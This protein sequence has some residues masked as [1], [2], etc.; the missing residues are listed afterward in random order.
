MNIKRTIVAVVTF[1]AGLYFILDFVVPRTLPV[2]ST[3]GVFVASDPAVVTVVDKNGQTIRREITPDV[4]ILTDQRDSSGEIKKTE[5]KARNTRA[6]AAITLRTAMVEVAQVV[7][8]PSGGA[9]SVVTTDGKTIR[10]G[11]GEGFYGLEDKSPEVTPVPGKR[12]VVDIRDARVQSMDMGA[13]T[14]LVK[15]KSKRLALTSGL[16]VLKQARNEQP[17]EV[18]A[19]EAKVGDTITVGPNTLFADNRDTAAQFNT[20]IETM[21][22]GMGLLSLALVNGRKLAKR[23]S[24]WYTAAFFFVAV[25]FGLMTGIFKYYE[26]NTPQRA[27]SDLIATQVLV[28][29][30]STVFSLLAFYMASAAYRA[31]RVRTAEA[32]LMMISALIIMLGQT[33]FGMYLTGWLGPRYEALWLPNVAGWLLRQPNSALVRGLVFGVTLGA[34]ATALRYWLNLERSTAMRGED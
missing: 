6:G 20:I 24:D 15:G 7:P 27:F 1:V 13:V 12:V 9:P 25:V 10:L 31:F 16:V 2:V 17:S 3:T 34:I 19:F 4:K 22:L 21:A 8:S 33:P 32:A 5:I 26:P 23:E 14:L 29:I 11:P 28:A 18:Q 30:G